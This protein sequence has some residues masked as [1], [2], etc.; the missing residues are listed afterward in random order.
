VNRPVGPRNPA[1]LAGDGFPH[2]IKGTPDVSPAT[3]QYVRA[4]HRGLGVLATRKFLKGSDFSTSTR[5]TAEVKS[6]AHDVA[7]LSPILVCRRMPAIAG[8][9]GCPDHIQEVLLNLACNLGTAGFVKRE[10]LIAAASKGD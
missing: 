10:S 7:D 6:R 2:T 4:D 8:V 3:I 5:A 9:H 1:L